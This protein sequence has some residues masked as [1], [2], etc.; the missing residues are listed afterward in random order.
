MRRSSIFLA[1]IL[2]M[3]L[4]IAF[5][6]YANNE[7][8]K[9]VGERDDIIRKMQ[10][11]DSIIDSLLVPVNKD[12]IS[13]VYFYR[14]EKGKIISYGQLDSL[15]SYYERQNAMQDFIILTAKKEFNFDYSIKQDNDKI[16]LKM[17]D[18][19]YTV[20]KELE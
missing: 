2:F 12:T 11:R 6:I 14:D 7:L 9:Q 13:V 1:I 17:W 18:K 19:K 15:C 16:I 3:S 4:F 20:F 10:E 8:D 5:L